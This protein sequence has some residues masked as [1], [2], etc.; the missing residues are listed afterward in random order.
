MAVAVELY[1]NL[2]VWFFIHFYSF[3]SRS[4]HVFLCIPS[5][6]LCLEIMLEKISG[7]VMFCGPGRIDNEG[8]DCL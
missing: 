1:A 7:V 2:W 3:R 8:V 6:T 5:L 4:Y